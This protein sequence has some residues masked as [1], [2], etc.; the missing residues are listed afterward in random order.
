MGGASAEREISLASGKN[1]ADHLPRDRYEVVMLDTLALMTHNPNV[2]AELLAPE[3]ARLLP[4]T[5]REG[6]EQTSRELLPATAIVQPESKIDV[7][8]LALHGRFGE[9]GTLQGLLELI[10]I[11]FVGS[12]TLASALAMDKVMAKKIFRAEGLPT[13]KS[14][15]VEKHSFSEADLQRLESMLPAVIKPVRQGSS[16]GISLVDEAAALHAAILEAFRFDG[17]LLVEERIVGR[18][19]TAGVIGNRDL[20]ALPVV[21]IIPKRDF[22]DYKAKY[23]A[24]CSDEICPADIPAELAAEAQSLALRA[25]RAL[26]CRG[27]SRTDLILG[28]E[29][30]TIL[31]VNT[32]PG[33]TENSLIPKAAKAAGISFPELLHH[34]I[35]LALERE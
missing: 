29:G 30:F 35:Q 2:P 27:L 12:G 19:F 26:D 10:G 34:L 4:A 31:E 8:F 23:D 6:I 9:D 24:A 28:P 14:C 7:A 3:R 5:V 21:E 18:E 20:T 16:I 22:F 11:P 13:P 32:L 17:R 25:H 15:V 33:L 1:I